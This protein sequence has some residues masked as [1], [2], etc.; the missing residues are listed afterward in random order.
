VE[1]GVLYDI[2]LTKNRGQVSYETPCIAVPSSSGS[3]VEWKSRSQCVW[4]DDEFSQNEI[5]LESRY[6][7]RHIVERHAPETRRFFTDFLRLSDAGV[8]ELLADLALMQKGNR[9]DPKRVYR[10]YERIESYRRS[11]LHLIKHV[12]ARRA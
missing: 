12:S 8:T 6:A 5:K 4:G 10:L 2:V 1:C 11:A 9:E 7:I 3:S